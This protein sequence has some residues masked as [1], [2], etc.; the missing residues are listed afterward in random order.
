[1]APRRG[2]ISCCN[3][4][5]SEDH[6]ALIGEGTSEAGPVWADLGSGTGAFTLALASLLGPAATI[7]SVDRDSEALAVQKQ[8]FAVRF[9]RMDVR[10]IASDM[11][12]LADL[13]SLDG[14]IAANS[15]HYVQDLLPVVSRIFEI[16]APAGRLVVVEYDL[17]RPS[18]WVPYPLPPARWSEVASRAGFARTRVL[19]TRP[20]RFNRRVYSALSLKQG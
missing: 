3:S 2:S 14:V 9:P 1:M 6:L 19:A 13:P 18:P 8:A 10:F 5:D 20:S 4:V 15:F 17:R 11:G 16:L 12:R 7:F